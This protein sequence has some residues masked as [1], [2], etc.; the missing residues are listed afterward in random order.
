MKTFKCKRPLAEVKILLRERGYSIPRSSQEQYNRGSDWILFV[1]KKDR[2]LYNTIAATFT[3]FD[4][5]TDEVLG[6]HLSTHLE[7]E[8]WYL[9]LLNTFY[10]EPE[11]S[12]HGT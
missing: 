12:D 8:S 5:K 7:S 11:N 6:T 3:V 10:I 2:I 1:G 9:D 4:L